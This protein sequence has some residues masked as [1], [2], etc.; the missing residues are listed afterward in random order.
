MESLPRVP[1]VIR[2][3]AR[4][5]SILVFV[6]VLLIIFVPTEK[7]IPDSQPNPM[8]M[9]DAFLLSLYGVAVLG[10]LLAWWKEALGGVINL[11]CAIVQQIAFWIIKDFWDWS[12]ILPVLVLT[13][14]GILFLTAWGLE[15]KNKRAA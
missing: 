2:W 15:R 4:A 3:I 9:E 14:P 5:W 8:A 11:T 7:G 10:L 13:I 1:R 6:S 12:Q